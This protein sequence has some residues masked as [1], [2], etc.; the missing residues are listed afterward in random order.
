MRRTGMLRSAAA[1]I[2]V[3]MWPPAA[4]AQTPPDYGFTWATITHPG[5]PAYPG[6]PNPP[7][8][9]PE[10]RA[11]G[12]G[13]VGYEYRIATSELSIANW[14]EFVN[15]FAVQASFPTEL[16]GQAAFTRSVP[17]NIHTDPAYGGPGRQYTYEP[18]RANNPLFGGIRWRDAAMFCN[19]LHNGKTSDPAALWSGAYDTSTWD[20]DGPPYTDAL[21]HQ[22]D[23]QFWIPSLDEWMK[24][25]YWDP[26]HEGLDGWRTYVNG[27]DTPPV[28]GMPGEPGA[29]TSA[30]LTNGPNFNPEDIALGSY[31]LALS[32][33]GLLDTGSGNY[34]WLED[35]T[36]VLELSNRRYKGA[37]AGADPVF[38]YV[39]AM[40]SGDPWI[41]RSASIRLASSIP[42]PNT[43]VGFLVVLVSGGMTRRRAQNVQQLG[44]DG[45]PSCSGHDGDGKRGSSAAGSPTV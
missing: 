13:S 17:L 26:Q 3:W 22:P 18:W 40:Q 15:T 32:P 9:L 28:S 43:A 38:S 30:G 36:S 19:W 41:G 11:I 44:G 24:A 20:S 1:A 21:T 2:G 5:N 34:E 16:F 42:A 10:T 7:P 23:A 25:V 39:G 14:T 6:N 8:D 29:T 4:L 12:R 27:S 33:W 37:R 35:S 31:P 45:W